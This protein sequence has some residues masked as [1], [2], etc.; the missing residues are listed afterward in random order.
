MNFKPFAADPKKSFGRQFKEAPSTLRNDF[1]E[2]AI[3]L[4]IR[5]LLGG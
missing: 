4:F 2:I 5:G 3:V 1:K